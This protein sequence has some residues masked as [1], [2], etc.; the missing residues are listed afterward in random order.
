MQPT[1]IEWADYSWNPIKGLCPVGCFYCYAREMYKRFKWDEVIRCDLYNA[2]SSMPK[3]GSKIFVCS[4]FELFHPSVKERW[5]DRI[6]DI[7]NAYRDR[8]FIILTKLP[9]N[10]DRDMPSNV[11]LG[12]TVV[13]SMR[14][15]RTYELIKSYARIK[16]VSFE[17][18]LGMITDD[19][20]DHL[21]LVDW[22]IVGRL[23]GQG[24][25]YDP[26]MW[27]ISEIEDVAKKHKIP[28]FLKNNLKDIWE[29]KLIQEYPE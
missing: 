26:A 4:T 8:T 3:P 24:K 7:I 22:I 11:W 21:Q 14:I 25:D 10:I 29:G 18:L 28:L 12:T 13:D 9:Q 16:F 17:P 2:I 15:E 27:W 1:N 20:I 23:T 5:R 6:F 19:E